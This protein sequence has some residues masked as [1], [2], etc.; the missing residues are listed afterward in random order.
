MADVKILQ[1]QK[2]NEV[3]R[4]KLQD[5][6]DDKKKAISR[7]NKEFE[8]KCLVSCRNIEFIHLLILSNYSRKIR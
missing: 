7:L 3:I 4:R 6:T 2:D 8:Q 1:L 5:A